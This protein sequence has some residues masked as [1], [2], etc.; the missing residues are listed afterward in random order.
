VSKEL[1][2]QGTCQPVAP[3]A[4]MY[5]LRAASGDYVGEGGTLN[6]DRSYAKRYA[7]EEEAREDAKANRIYCNFVAEV[8]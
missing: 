2:P 7:S 5:V 6:S 1:P 3:L 8:A 4:V